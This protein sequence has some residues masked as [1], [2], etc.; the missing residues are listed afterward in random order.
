MA[1]FGIGLAALGRP[2]YM[3]LGHAGDL[4]DTSID[5]MFAQTCE[6]LD[7]AY[8]LGIRH[9]DT[10]RSYGTGEQFAARW[11]A[12]RG[13]Q[14]IVVSSK[15]GYHYTAGWQTQAPVHEVK[16]LSLAHF[17]SQWLETQAAL[18]PRLSI[19]QIHSVT[20][21]S[22][23]LDDAA[24]LDRLARMR[25]AG[26]AAGLSSTGADQ[27]GVVRKAASVQ[28]GGRRVFDWVQA[29]WNVLEP[30]VGPA[31]AEAKA[32]GMRTIVKESLANGRL[33]DRGDV[34]ELKAAARERGTTPDALALAVAL[35]QPFIDVLL[36]GAAT[37]AQ[38]QTNTRASTVDPSGFAL[39]P[40]PAKEYWAKRQQLVWT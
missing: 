5:G 12:A 4:R 10:A 17:E 27:A 30:S 36:L 33:S 39:T 19:Y 26:V 13:H 20:L 35:A 22:G 23:V 9:L 8:A 40:E 1:R 18:G 16:D 38:V 37:V 15:W 6:V 29:T 25:D 7:A 34:L 14:D 32:L 31:L 2:G 21:E 11:L 24:V 28:R 3:T